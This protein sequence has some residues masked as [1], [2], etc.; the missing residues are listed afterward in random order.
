MHHKNCRAP[1]CEKKS[2]TPYGVYCRAHAATKR[3]HGHP[4][5]KAVTK[6]DLKPFIKRVQERRAKH[7]TAK[8]WET[9][10]ARWNALVEF[11]QPL[12]ESHY[13]TN[14]HRRSAAREI[15]KLGVHVEAKEVVETVLAI[16]LMQEYD[17]NRFRSDAAFDYQMVRRIRGLTRL[18]SGSWPN[19]NTG[20]VHR[21]AKEL[22]PRTT[23]AM[24]HNVKQAL[25]VA[26]VW[27][28]NAEREEEERKRKETLEF[29]DQL[30]ELA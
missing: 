29:Y 4:E 25:G 1:G 9:M 28:A 7:P 2:I 10:E 19:P 16:H 21:A 5:Q 23:E 27:L 20:R 18:N 12:A 3:R 11:L 26:G 8:A 17:P 15:V 6:G 22:E 13:P 30:R 14:K 24:A